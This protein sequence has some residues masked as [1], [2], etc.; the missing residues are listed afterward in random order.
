MYSMSGRAVF[1]RVL[2]IL[3]TFQSQDDDYTHGNPGFL[4]MR[5]TLEGLNGFN[6]NFTAESRF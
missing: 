3:M 2:L 1:G 6:C 4:H 5:A